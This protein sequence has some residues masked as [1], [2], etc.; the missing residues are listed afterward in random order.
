MQE[1]SSKQILRYQR[2][3]DAYL[4]T[5]F[6]LHPNYRTQLNVKIFIERHNIE[7][8]QFQALKRTPYILFS[9][10]DND[11]LY[12]INCDF[13]CFVA[14]YLPRL[15]TAIESRLI[16]DIFEIIEW[17]SVG[18]IDT[19]A[20]KEDKERSRFTR[21]RKRITD[22]VRLVKNEHHEKFGRGSISNAAFFKAKK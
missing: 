13:Y 11:Y 15:Y 5:T 9:S 20:P 14:R 6:F 18:D 10:K 3:W 7:L 1:F 19:A 4:L 21:E 2:L 12:S 17:L 8:E 16:D 22:A